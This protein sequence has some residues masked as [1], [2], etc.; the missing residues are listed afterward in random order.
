VPFVV[1]ATLAMTA[2][3]PSA[4]VA[5]APESVSNPLAGATLYRS[6]QGSAVWALNNLPDDAPSELVQATARIA[7]QPTAVWFTDPFRDPTAAVDRLVDEAA[8]ARQVPMIVVYGIPDRDCG[9]YSKGG[10]RTDAQYLRWVQQIAAGIGGR[11]AIVIIEPDA[12]AQAVDGC[13]VQGG[14]KNRYALLSEAVTLLTEGE[15]RVYLDAGNATWKLD[16]TELA[17]AL[18]RSGVRRATGIA[19][20][21]SNHVSTARSAEYAREM[22]RRVGV[23]RYVIDVSRNGAPVEPGDW[24]N[25]MTARL[26][27]SPTTGTDEPGADAYLWIK[28]PGNSDGECGRG[29]PPAGVWWPQAAASLAS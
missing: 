1:V 6:P 10:A 19:V 23:T 22:G 29:E 26:G 25:S 28:Q 7:A 16:R 2:C 24:C 20:N 18:G 12:V 5:N 11:R 3:R 4:E 27:K 9:L 8:V 15:T 14:T 21:V 13:Q 17:R